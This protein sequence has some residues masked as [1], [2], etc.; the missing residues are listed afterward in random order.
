MRSVLICLAAASV[1]SLGCSSSTSVP[2]T[3]D[4]ASAELDAD[5][6]DDVTVDP[7]DE[8]DAYADALATANDTRNPGDFVVFRFSGSFTPEP[9][10]LTQRVVSR[11]DE[12]ITID[13]TL[14]RGHR[15][16]TLRVRMSETEETAGELISVS[17]LEQTREV[18]TA[19]S[20]YEEMMSR[21][22]MSADENEELL[23]TEDLTLEVSGVKIP[24]TKTSF[25]V[26]IAGHA[27]T[28]STF[29]S[30][31]FP[32]GDVGGE[33]ATDEGGTFYKAELLEIGHEPPAPAAIA[34]HD[35][36]TI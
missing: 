17:R 35:P 8:S 7:R 13:M 16:R 32:W 30:E 28:L 29:S 22:V 1:L 3:A 19:I 26:R 4:T 34:Q 12:A 33:I 27:A 15:E 36:S 11:S 14:A 6:L 31:T 9:L 25:R 5:A 24:C 21:V 23:D 2:T 18:P 20:A 10:T